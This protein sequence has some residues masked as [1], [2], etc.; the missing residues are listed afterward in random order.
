MGRRGEHNFVE[1]RG[2]IL[3]DGDEEH[4]SGEE[5]FFLK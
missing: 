4:V 5:N 3:A 2:R 1:L